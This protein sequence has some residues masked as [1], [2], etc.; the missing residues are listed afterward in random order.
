MATGPHGAT[1]KRTR[2]P[3]PSAGSSAL[4]HGPASLLLHPPGSAF[5]CGWV[6]WRRTVLL[7]LPFFWPVFK[8]RG[9]ARPSAL[10]WVVCRSR[11]KSTS[12]LDGTHPTLTGH[13]PACLK[14]QLDAEPQDLCISAPK[15]DLGPN[16]VG[17][18]MWG[19]ARSNAS[20]RTQGAGFSLPKPC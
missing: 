14:P 15:R 17:A 8:G 10:L 1:N 16:H 13:I 19:D 20:T 18:L 5:G 9:R 3:N 12:R 7:Q 6:S 4:Q 11:A 2:L